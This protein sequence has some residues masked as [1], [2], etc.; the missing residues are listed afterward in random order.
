MGAIWRPLER[1]GGTSFSMLMLL[2]RWCT[3]A[4]AFVSFSLKSLVFTCTAVKSLDRRA[5]KEDAQHDISKLNEASE[6]RTLWFARGDTLPCTRGQKVR[7]FYTLHWLDMTVGSPW[8]NSRKRDSQNDD[9][10]RF[11]SLCTRKSHNTL[12]C[13]SQIRISTET[14]LTCI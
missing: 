13:L 11:W 8:H 4:T 9:G 2:S 14:I 12:L 6:V 1:T 3:C 7:A 5:T 10:S